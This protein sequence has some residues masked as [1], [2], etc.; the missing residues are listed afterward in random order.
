M[1]QEVISAL[2]ESVA[3]S[4]YTALVLDRLA[5]QACQVVESEASSIFAHDR[6]VPGTAI[7]VAACGAH[8]EI[9]GSRIRVRADFR[10]AVSEDGALAT[11]PACWRDELRG[12]LTA[13][14]ASGGRF[15]PRELDV[16][17]QLATTAGAALD[18][19]EFREHALRAIRAKVSGMVRS[20]DAHDGYTA[21]HS[22][23]VVEWSCALG[24]RLRL[25]LPDLLELELGALLHDLARSGFPGPSCASPPRSTATSTGSCAAIRCGGPSCSRRSRGWSRWRRSCASTTSAGTGTGIPTAWRATGSRSPAASSPCATP[26]TR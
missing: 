8:D 13:Q 18:H 7:A 11:L 17:G 24:E 3:A 21:G 4:G 6:R 19:A 16:L 14:A 5:K 1:H 26:T 22:G 23:E 20:I 12:A 25:G 15:G 10:G 2:E 9:V